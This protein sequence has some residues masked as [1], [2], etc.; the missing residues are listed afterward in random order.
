MPRLS[1][2]AWTK[3]KELDSNL[4]QSYRK[5]NKYSLRPIEDDPLSFLVC[6]N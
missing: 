6:H 1:Y 4:C 2:I 3:Q 5:P